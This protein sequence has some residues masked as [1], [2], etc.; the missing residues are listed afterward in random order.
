MPTRRAITRIP[1]EMRPIQS[2]ISIIETFTFTKLSVSDV[3]MQT[4]GDILRTITCYTANDVY[5]PP[6]GWFA[7][8]TIRQPR[9]PLLA[10]A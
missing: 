1:A 6:R 3:V 4:S 2:R 7:N 10:Q 8:S 9:S 5:V